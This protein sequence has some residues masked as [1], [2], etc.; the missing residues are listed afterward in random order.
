[1]EEI[2]DNEKIKSFLEIVISSEKYITRTIYDGQKTFA[3]DVTKDTLFI[4]DTFQG[5][6]AMD[7]ITP[8][9]VKAISNILEE[10]KT[11]QK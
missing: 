4:F 5:N 7:F 6:Y 8:D 1:M 10:V 3:L 9:G 2:T 11:T